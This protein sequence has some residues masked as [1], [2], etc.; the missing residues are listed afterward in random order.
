M[1]IPLTKEAIL[2]AMEK[3]SPDKYV[4]SPRVVYEFKKPRS[5]VEWI[6][7]TKEEA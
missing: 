5:V 1:L 4:A 6:K 2:Y 7:W 3:D